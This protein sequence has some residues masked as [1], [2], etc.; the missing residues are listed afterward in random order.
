MGIPI[1]WIRCARNLQTL[2]VTARAALQA[3]NPPPI[4]VAHMPTNTT[5]TSDNDD[6]PQRLLDPEG[7]LDY[8]AVQHWIKLQQLQEE[9][10][11]KQ[12][13]KDTT[14]AP[15]D[16]VTLEQLEDFE[17]HLSS[18]LDQQQS[19]L[20]R[21][22]SEAN[23]KPAATK[24]KLNEDGYNKMPAVDHQQAANPHPSNHHTIPSEGMTGTSHTKDAPTWLR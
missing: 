3:A 19:E 2:Q 17:A 8:Q 24:D 15:V 13:T 16:E 9:P 6:E 1:A 10:N 4:T 21:L 14:S 20:Q 12:A 7:D 11:R 23:K 18:R 5:G 22:Q